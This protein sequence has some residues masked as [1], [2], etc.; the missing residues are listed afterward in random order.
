MKRIN[1]DSLI[2]DG[3]KFSVLV[4]FPSLLTESLNQ[5]YVGEC[6]TLYNPYIK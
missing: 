1:L 6:L 5:Y 2:T 3:F 4:L